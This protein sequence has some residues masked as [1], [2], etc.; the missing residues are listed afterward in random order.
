MSAEIDEQEG[1]IF[2]SDDYELAACSVCGKVL[3]EMSV[4]FV[5]TDE[6]EELVV[7]CDQ[8]IS[9]LQNAEKYEPNKEYVL[10]CSA[11]ISTASS[12]DLDS[13]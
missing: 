11:I 10:P 4:D 12:L 7:A 8:Y 13:H 3:R 2:T 6:G 5:M 9:M 1:T